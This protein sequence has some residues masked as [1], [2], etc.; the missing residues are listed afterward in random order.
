MCDRERI[1]EMEKRIT[2]IDKE[3]GELL[4]TIQDLERQLELTRSSVKVYEEKDR[5]N[6]RNVGYSIVILLIALWFIVR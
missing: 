3:N 5:N 6:R 4:K 1:Q 2:A